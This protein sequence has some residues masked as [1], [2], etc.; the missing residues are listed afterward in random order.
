MA[1][2]MDVDAP[3]AAAA[4]GAG[5]STSKSSSYMLP[6]VRREREGGVQS[7]VLPG[8]QCNVACGPRRPA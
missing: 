2:A 4:G 8:M 3:G 7:Q 6:W 5:P 1:S